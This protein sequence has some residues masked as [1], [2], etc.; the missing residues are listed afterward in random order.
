M[1]SPSAGDVTLKPVNLRLAPRNTDSF[2]IICV[3][4]FVF[5]FTIISITS[6]L[7][8]SPTADEPVH[9][10]AGYSYLKWGDFRANPEHPPLAKMWAAL[11]LMVLNVKDSRDAGPFWQLISENS[12]DSMHTVA[13]AGKMLFGD[14]DADRLFF[15][16]KLQIVFLAL[17]L[18]YFI[19]RWGEEVFGQLSAAV[20][21]FIYCLDPNVLAH[22][23][24]VH[25][26]IAFTTF[27]FIGTYCF[28]RVLQ[29]L[30]WPRLAWTALLFGLAAIT[31]YAYLSIF[32]VWG[33][34]AL[35]RIASA[36]SIEL[37]L[38]NPRPISGRLE[39]TA[40]I[41]L[42]IF[43][44][45]I[46]A[47]ILIW[48]V[49]GFRYDA[50]AGGSRPLPMAEQ[51]P[52]QQFLRVIVTSL[53]HYRLFPEAWIYGQLYVFNNLQREAYLLGAYS[54]RGF[55]LYFPVAFAVKTPVPTL[56]LFAGS[57]ALCLRNR[58]LRAR[59]VF[60]FVPIAIYFSLGVWSR[61]NIGLR[62]IVPIYP[63]LFVL[64]G[65]T[66]AELWRTKSALKRG[67]VVVLGLWSFWS[68]AGIYPHFLS[69]FNESA[70]GRYNG[71]KFLLDS[72]LDW[73]QDLKELKRWI[74][75]NHV[76]KIQFLY[77]GFH[78]V[79]EPRYYGI[80]AIY[81]PGSWVAPNSANDSIAQKPD[82]L[83]ISINHLYG[84]YLRGARREDFIR[85]FRTIEPV[86][87]IGRSI[88]IYSINAAIENLRNTL[89]NNPS[90]ATAHADL[91]SLLENQGK[92]VEA[93]EHYR[94]A[95]RLDPGLTKALYN[96]G[97]VVGKQGQ[98]AE[99][100]Q[101]MER[102]AKS[103]PLDE[104]IHYDFGILL[105]MQSDWNGAERQ[106]H[107]T[108]KLDKT[109]IKAKYNL[110]IALQK[111]GEI[112]GAIGQLREAV[113]LDSTYTRAAL[114]LGVIL[115]EQGVVDEAIVYLQRAVQMEPTLAEGYQA[116]SQ[117]FTRQ[118]KTDEAVK[119]IEQA[120]RIIRA[121]QA[122]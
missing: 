29:K 30:T 43:C 19:Y 78:D 42:I 23:Q 64:A 69:Y 63:F 31:K 9:L 21:L 45:L 20:A 47:Y 28:W 112:Q 24:I 117:A 115:L 2:R 26:D 87:H 101:L 71:H 70:G 54:D 121:R 120:L 3:G 59:A 15:F 107:E 100:V 58:D 81:L 92:V 33:A 22:S 106:F 25:T 34:L 77:F 41:A 62:H 86:A 114:R 118:G 109:Y 5:I 88:N 103:S 93:M 79:V 108:L 11:P 18:G 52:D 122:N 96:L 32:L 6:L 90:S 105:A 35:W 48:I 84:H 74:D 110:A 46:T 44:C 95:L 83:A 73:G 113:Q 14:N 119:S 40:W 38:G 89:Q 16:A 37:Q 66:A 91:G 51:L 104:D 116:L 72:N 12:P 99:A 98:L 17:L 68:A 4:L 10:F 27:F 1:R 97:M 60:L 102:A 50:V 55:L 65:A 76:G 39:K 49:Y 67:S 13:L 94:A 85:V 8:K 82:Y 75:K 80:D 57:V 53:I 7:Q 56:L 36:Q 111:K 61:I